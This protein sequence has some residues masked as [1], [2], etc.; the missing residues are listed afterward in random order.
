VIRTAGSAAGLRGCLRVGRH[1]PL[2]LV[3]RWQMKPDRGASRVSQVTPLGSE[4]LD[5]EQSV[6]LGRVQVALHDGGA[7]RAVIDDLDQDAVRYAG[8]DDGVASPHGASA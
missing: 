3:G 6:S 7:R 2:R 4:V 1:D 5:Q 8:D